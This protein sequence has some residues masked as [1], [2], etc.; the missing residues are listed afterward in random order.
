[1]LFLRPP[2]PSFAP[3]SGGH[4][5]AWTAG[6]ITGAGK[7]T[8]QRI[9]VCPFPNEC[10]RAASGLEA[11]GSPRETARR[12]SAWWPVSKSPRNFAR[13]AGAS[14]ENHS[15]HSSTSRSLSPHSFADPAH[16]VLAPS[17]PPCVRPIRLTRTVYLP[18]LTILSKPPTRPV[19]PQAGGTTRSSARATAR[20]QRPRLR[21]AG[22]WQ[23]D[24]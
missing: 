18:D 7:I 20:C 15:L 8:L 24:P 9:G 5:F 11:S 6:S 22:I 19:P 13:S 1:M 12:M 16:A 10:K 2:A 21:A 14:L 23:L 17:E 3:P 4:V